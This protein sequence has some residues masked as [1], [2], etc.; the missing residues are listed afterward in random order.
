MNKEEF[1]KKLEVELKITQSSEHTLK[2][3]T[4]F[5]SQFLDFINKNP[6][7]ITEDDLKFYIAEKLSERAA[8]STIM[9]LA[10]IK[11]AHSGILKK[12][13]T[14][15]IKRPKREKISFCEKKK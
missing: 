2:N 15:S 4:R 7:E 5:N 3:Y 11:Y 8:I 13:P 10:A 1:L 6:E 9:F 14:A 12:D